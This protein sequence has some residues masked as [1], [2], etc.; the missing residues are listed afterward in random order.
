M[1]LL[2]STNND[3]DVLLA[4]FHQSFVV[5]PDVEKVFE[6]LDWIV[7]RSQFGYFVPSMLLTG[8]TGAGKSTVM[9][10]YINNRVNASDVLTITVR[11]SL[12][13]TLLHICSELRVSPSRRVKPSEDGL[14]NFLI[15]QLK[16]IHLKLLVIEESQHLFETATQLERQKIRDKL[17]II[18]DE[19]RLP[20]V[21]IGIPT[22]KLILEDS[23]W[24]RRIMIK[25]E[26][27][28]IRITS[29]E[30]LD[31]Y[32]DFLEGLEQQLP[33]PASP[34]LSEM[35]IAIRLLAMSKGMLGLIKEIVGYALELAFLAEKNQITLGEFI[36]AFDAIYGKDVQNPF[37]IALE[38]LLIPQIIE[39]ED[40]IIDASSGDIKFTK[41]IFKDMSLADLLR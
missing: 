25:R 3:V 23:Q 39:Y 4:E 40:Y 29:E 5:Y 32:I 9:E 10:N 8:G 31:N 26:L 35:E 15:K 17:K 36:A 13:A 33:I 19:C 38:K 14:F 18:S 21:F 6:G 34:N 1:T 37:E 41:Q 30:S 16:Q 11:P 2:Q 28:Y 24:D 27:P 12:L 7:R 20:V 22:A